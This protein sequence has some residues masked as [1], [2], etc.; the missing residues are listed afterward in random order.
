MSEQD[1]PVEIPPGP[2]R[3]RRIILVAIVALVVL[4]A[5][6]VTK[7]WAWD[8]LRTGPAIAVID[9]WVYLEFGFNTGS[10]FSLLRDAEWA[11]ALFIVVTIAA[12]LYMGK[13]AASLPTAWSSGFVA[14]AL[15]SAGALGNLHDRLLRTMEVVGRVRHG[16]VDFL[17]IYY[18]PGRA[19][20]TFNVADIALVVGVGLLLIYLAQHGDA[21][22]AQAKRATA[23]P[24][25]TG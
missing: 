11:R 14:V 12:L 20:P 18:W 4:A 10:A 9:D 24:Q 7:A 25:P 17:K 13:L 6:L 19:W 5:D 3:A 2:P 1:Q 22:D 15:V 23:T 21:L 16:V 8:A